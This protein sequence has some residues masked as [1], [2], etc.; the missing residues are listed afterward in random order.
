MKE[1]EEEEKEKLNVSRKPSATSNL[2]S[3]NEITNEISNLRSG[4]GS[5]L[6]NY[7]TELMESRFGREFG[8]VR[9][10]TNTKAAESAQSVNALAYTVGQDIVFGTGQYA[11]RTKEGQ[12]LIAHELAHVIQQKNIPVRVQRMTEHAAEVAHERSI[13]REEESKKAISSMSVDDRLN[14]IREIHGYWWVGPSDEAELEYIWGTFGNSLEQIASDNLELWKKSLDY[15]AELDDLPQVEAIKSRYE[16]DVKQKAVDYLIIN[17]NYINEEL[18]R[19]GLWEERESQPSEEKRK[20]MADLQEAADQFRKAQEYQNELLRLQVGY[21]WDIEEGPG[22]MTKA[23]K[24]PGTFSPKVKPHMG[25]SGNE[26]PPLPAWEKVKDQYDRLGSVMTGLSQK[27]PAIFAVSREEKVGELAKSTPEQARLIVR[28]AFFEV[29]E[30]IE[31]TFPKIHSG[32]LDWRD[33]KPIHEQFRTAQTA[34][35]S[36]KNWSL[37]LNKWIVEDILSDHESKEFWISLGL[38]VLAAAAFVV[39]ELVSFGT[40]TF[41]IAAGVGIAATGIQVGRSWEHYFDLAQASKANIK[42]ELAL[43]SQGQASAALI[44]AILDTAFAFLDVYGPAAKGV[45]AVR[46]V[47]KEALEVGEKKIAELASRETAE[48]AISTG[49]RIQRRTV[50]GNILKL[51]ERGQLVICSWPC[52]F[53][54]SRYAR[55]LSEASSHSL[56]HSLDD[57]ERRFIDAERV[58]DISALEKAFDDAVDVERQLAERHVEHLS[59]DISGSVRR[60]PVEAGAAVAVEQQIG[61]SLERLN[62]G[63]PVVSRLGKTGDFWD[64]VTRSSYDHVGAGS[65]TAGPGAF[66][67]DVYGHLHL[68]QGVDF[69]V[70]DL[71]AM[72]S[73]DIQIVLEAF[74]TNPVFSS[75]SRRL[76][77]VR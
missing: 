61:R 30:N 50:G 31:K 40:A 56:S 32:D 54:R 21:D 27:H 11:P 12:R 49:V 14:R 4:G 29:L 36:G 45:R 46:G 3:S 25:P 19:L 48:A 60:R 76:L 16:N 62:P 15:G 55:E 71:R 13:K 74:R 57:I 64:P 5:L 18:T 35:A 2:Q 39:A 58:G 41:F 33:L 52:E 38:S 69:V 77:I 73:G 53:L 44:G 6:D 43:V 47:E 37:P 34:S 65:G 23:K 28:T 59:L 70:A 68:K 9:L 17:R 24:Y 7:T 22:G 72:S 8:S 63:D 66:L 1:E 75:V 51:T 20:N 67:G 10:H 42:P 26:V